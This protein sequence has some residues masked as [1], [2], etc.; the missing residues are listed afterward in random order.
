MTIELVV[1]DMDGV[2]VDFDRDER[3]RR[4]AQATGLPPEVID[5]RLY[6]SD[7]ETAAEAGRW[8][9]GVEYLAEVN[10]RL[11]SSLTREQWIEARREAVRPRA[12]VLAMAERL[13]VTRAI[14][15]L[16]NNG[17]L[18]DE[19]LPEI[20]PEVVRVFGAHAHTSSRFGTRKPDPVVF[21]RLL[22]VYGVAADAA[23]MLDDD[24]ASVAGARQAG[25]HA[26]HVT[27]PA[28]IRAGLAQLGLDP[29]SPPP[30]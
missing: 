21:Q 8:R 6:R 26:V 27:D 13:G 3:L 30:D 11:G 23:C 1:F 4:L 16:T 22:A 2:L 5:E 10:R 17:A 7:F 9:T 14:A 20:A 12:E 25:L 19:A 18:L 28:S 15:V 29:G 24:P